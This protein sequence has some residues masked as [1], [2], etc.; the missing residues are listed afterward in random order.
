[1]PYQIKQFTDG[2]RVVSINGKVLSNKPLTYQQALKQMRAVGLKE[3]L[4]NGGS[5]FTDELQN[6]NFNPSKYL[7]IVR[8]K[9]KLNGYNPKNINFSTNNIHKLEIEDDNGKIK[10][11][12]RSGY[13][14]H[15]IYQ[16]LEKSKDV[17]M[18]YADMKRNVFRSSHTKIKGNWASNPF[19]PN[20]LALRILW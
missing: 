19:S 1:M 16:F 11:F 6:I 10:R 20:N 4:Y 13:G 7:K 14:D 3:G 2:F 9:A 18:G 8:K 5:A 12:G 15:I 17:P